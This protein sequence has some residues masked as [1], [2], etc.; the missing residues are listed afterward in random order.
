MDFMSWARQ[1]TA[2]VVG[3]IILALVVGFYLSKKQSSALSGG[4]AGSSTPTSDTSGLVNGKIVY[5]PTST[6]FSTSNI[7]ADYSNDPLLQSI[8]NS[9]IRVNSPTNNATA[10]T[11]T[12]TTT[13]LPPPRPQPQPLPQ[14]APAPPPV[15]L[16]PVGPPMQS[17]PVQSPPSVLPPV[18][19]PPIAVNCPPG[20]TIATSSMPSYVNGQMVY[21]SEC[22]PSYGGANKFGPIA[23]GSTF[24]EGTY[25]QEVVAPSVAVNPYSSSPFN[26]NAATLAL[27]M[28]A[29]NRGGYSGITNNQSVNTY[30]P[31]G[32]SPVQSALP[33][34]QPAP[35]TGVM[36]VAPKPTPIA[37]IAQPAPY[38]GVMPTVANVNGLPPGYKLLANGSVVKI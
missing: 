28:D 3:V 36:P 9:P 1:H 23:L 10:T 31:L 38:T 30:N 8:T 6:T 22:I 5:V 4:T 32:A 15:S 14:P 29:A 7:G 12:N 21:K 33:I 17:P 16:P 11:T 37:P 19:K 13:T 18:V 26:L 20:Y 27:G 35:Y 2:I 25:G 34:A 24:K